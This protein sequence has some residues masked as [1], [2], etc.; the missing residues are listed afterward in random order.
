MESHS[1][2]YSLQLSSSVISP[3]IASS[4]MTH[5]RQNR[6]LMLNVRHDTSTP[7]TVLQI[8]VSVSTVSQC[9]NF[10]SCD[11]VVMDRNYLHYNMDTEV[12]HTISTRVLVFIADYAANTCITHTSA[13]HPS[14]K[15][16]HLILQRHTRLVNHC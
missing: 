14:P 6:R 10:I 7:Y 1:E 12:A 11:P 16:N 3:S 4:A 15:L 2:I 9:R 8:R 5:S 13:H